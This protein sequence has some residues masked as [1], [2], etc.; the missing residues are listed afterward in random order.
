MYRK[1]FIIHQI[2]ILIIFREK[3]ALQKQLICE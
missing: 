1:L 2:I 3:K